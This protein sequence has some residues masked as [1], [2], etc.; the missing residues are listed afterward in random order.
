L[1]A[2]VA[3]GADRLVPQEEQGMARQIRKRLSL[4]QLRVMGEIDYIMGKAQERDSRVVQDGVRRNHSVLETPDNCQIPSG[5]TE[6]TL[7]V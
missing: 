2:L 5:K 7:H 3:S 4:A 1:A 6:L